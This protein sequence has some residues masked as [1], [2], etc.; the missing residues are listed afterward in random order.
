MLRFKLEGSES[1]SRNAGGVSNTDGFDCSCRLLGRGGSSGA[2]FRISL[3][4]PVGAVIN[5][6]DNTGTAWLTPSSFHVGCYYQAY[7]WYFLIWFKAFVV[8][9]QLCQHFKVPRTCTSS[10]WRASRAVW[11]GCLLQEWVTWWWPQS[12]KASQSSGRRVSEYFCR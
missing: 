12:R 2:K 3:G 5:C 9:R 6:A 7:I 10:L 11:T 4:L 1:L 8:I